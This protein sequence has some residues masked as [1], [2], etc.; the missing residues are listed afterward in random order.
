MLSLISSSLAGL[1]EATSRAER[2]AQRILTAST[3]AAVFD[4]DTLRSGAQAYGGRPLDRPLP[5]VADV[6]ADMAMGLVELRLAAHAYKAGAAVTRTAD[7][8][9]RTLVDLKR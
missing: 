7:E 4:A 6:T 5:P 3:A 1:Y 2:A 8:M 9:A